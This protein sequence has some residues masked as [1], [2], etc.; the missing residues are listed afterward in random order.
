MG[1]LL[2]RVL[3]LSALDVMPVSL[4]SGE[5]KITWASNFYSL[6][7]DGYLMIMPSAL[8]K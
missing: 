7:L 4:T 3:G 2:L 5:D 6:L 1:I 8:K